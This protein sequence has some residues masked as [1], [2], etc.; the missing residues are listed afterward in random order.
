MAIQSLMAGVSFD[1]EDGVISSAVYTLA[2]GGGDP[3]VHDCNPRQ[4][5]FLGVFLR[6]VGAVPIFWPEIG[7][8]SDALRELGNMVVEAEE[9]RA[10]S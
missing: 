7:W 4:L 2:F 9:A 5:A 1:P 8:Y 3:T 6:S 10:A